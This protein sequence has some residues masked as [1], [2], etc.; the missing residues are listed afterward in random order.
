[1]RELSRWSERR[2]EIWGGE[3][4]SWAGT[5]VERGRRWEVRTIRDCELL[6]IKS[7]TPRRSPEELTILLGSAAVGCLSAARCGGSSFAIFM[8]MSAVLSLSVVVVISPDS[9]GVRCEKSSSCWPSRVRNERSRGLKAPISSLYESCRAGMSSA[10][11]LRDPEDRK[12]LM[13]GMTARPPE[14][15]AALVV[16]A[17]LAALG[18]L[19]SL[20][21]ADDTGGREILS[22]V[23]GC[24]NSRRPCTNSLTALSVRRRLAG[25]ATATGDSGDS[26]EGALLMGNDF[27]RLAAGGESVGAAV[28]GR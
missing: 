14:L 8:K 17:V 20:C 25:G 13:G 28:D 19:S 2:R 5:V 6:A 27:G 18:V 23:L 21:D 4:T 15:L 12:D 9:N 16:L 24:G 22:L 10:A 7:R 11:P 1:M 3:G 26:V